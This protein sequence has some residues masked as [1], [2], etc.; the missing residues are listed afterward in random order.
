VEDG[1]V[2]RGLLQIY[3]DASNETIYSS[4]VHSEDDPLGSLWDTDGPAA[5]EKLSHIHE[6]L[7]ETLRP[8]FQE[9]GIDNPVSV[10]DPPSGLIVGVWNQPHT[11]SSASS[12]PSLGFGY[13]AP[14]KLIY[15]P[16]TLGTPESICG[17][18]GLTDAS[19]RDIVLQ[20]WGTVF[21]DASIFLVNNDWVCHSIWTYRGDWAEESLLQAERAMYRLGTPRPWWLNEVYYQDNV[22]WIQSEKAARTAITYRKSRVRNGWYQFGLIVGITIMV[23]WFQKNRFS[24]QNDYTSI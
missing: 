24:R 17:V 11:G 14:T 22:E 16:N 20:P 13:T 15:E 5:V 10:I 1:H 6:G 18:P 12:S 7:M 21:R 4:T 23:G 2:C 8:L 19:Y 3:Y 9:A